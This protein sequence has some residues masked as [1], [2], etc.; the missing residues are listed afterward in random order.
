[1]RVRAWLHE[2][3]LGL[4]D[5]L[6]VVDE[7]FFEAPLPVRKPRPCKKPMPTRGPGASSTLTSQSHPPAVPSSTNNDLESRT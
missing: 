7:A 1:M 2:L 3:D 4:V 6:P 5:T